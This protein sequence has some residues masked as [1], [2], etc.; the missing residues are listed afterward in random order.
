[1]AIQSPLNDVCAI[2]LY[3]CRQWLRTS[4]MLAHCF[5]DK[6]VLLSCMIH[7]S[8]VLVWYAGLFGQRTRCTRAGKA[9]E[10]ASRMG[11]ER[12]GLRGGVASVRWRWLPESVPT[13]QGGVG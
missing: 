10:V 13:Y 9:E 4:D 6:S 8:I 1:M 5:Y 7:H 2:L 3:R 12:G 11:K